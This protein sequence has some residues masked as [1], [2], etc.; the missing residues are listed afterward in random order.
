MRTAP[1]LLLSCERGHSGVRGRALAPHV[2]QQPHDAPQQRLGH[3]KVTLPVD[4][5]DEVLEHEIECTRAEAGELLG[6]RAEVAVKLLR[7]LVWTPHFLHV[8]TC[9]TEPALAPVRKGVSRRDTSANPCITSWQSS[10]PS[11]GEAA[12]ARATEIVQV[13]QYLSDASYCSI[14]D[15]RSVTGALSLPTS[16]GT[17]TTGSHGSRRVKCSVCSGDEGTLLLRHRVSTNSLAG[18]LCTGGAACWRRGRSLYTF[19]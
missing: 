9:A 14:G 6:Q 17:S 2:L 5:H 4:F 1:L 16:T 8:A 18:V 7:V 19:T 13:R 12:A 11:N 10:K 15:R 3:F